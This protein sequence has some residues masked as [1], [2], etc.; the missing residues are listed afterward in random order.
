[1]TAKFEQW[2]HRYRLDYERKN[3]SA[4]ALQPRLSSL[5]VFGRFLAEVKLADVTV[6]R[7][8]HVPAFRAW[9]FHDASRSGAPRQITS[10]NRVLI[11]TRHFLH[12]LFAEGAVSRD[13]AGLIEL[14]KEPQRLPRNILTPREARAILK[15]CDLH[16]ALGYRDRTLLEVIYSTGIRRAELLALVLA[17]VRLEEEILRI[18]GGK[19][20]KD[21]V[22]PLTRTAC[23]FLETYL[24]R[25]RPALLLG[26]RGTA[27]V[28]VSLKG[29]GLSF[30]GLARM[31]ARCGRRAGLKQ[32][33]TPHVWRHTCATHLLQNQA[34]LRHVQEILGHRSLATTER[35]LHVTIA[36][37]K[38]A[39]R[40]CHPRE[41]EH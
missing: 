5:R 33:V 16:T 34:N 6:L 30:D 19:G 3:L 12:F 14:A 25:V 22:V 24:K 2:L 28:F 39:H 37:L 1:M 10:Q 7:E 36:D 23:A 8:R 26:K 11:E 38:A 29:G 13:L 27:R 4:A 9:L 21:R 18:N 41:R 40:R 15:A 17:D 31:V 35:Y 32:R 20:A